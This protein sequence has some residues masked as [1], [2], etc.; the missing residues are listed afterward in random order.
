[1]KC[2]RPYVDFLRLPSLEQ[3]SKNWGQVEKV[4]GRKHNGATF[5]PI[6]LIPLQKEVFSREK[7]VH[8]RYPKVDLRLEFVSLSFDIMAGP[9]LD[10]L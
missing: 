4:W 10:V 5:D 8:K 6:A 2:D 9:V 3:R 1:M 7:A